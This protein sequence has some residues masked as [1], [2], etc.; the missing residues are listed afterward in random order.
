MPLPTHQLT[1]ARVTTLIFLLTMTS[2]ALGVDP[3]GA[4]N[5]L[6]LSLPVE[7]D[8]SSFHSPCI[9]KPFTVL[10]GVYWGVWE[11]TTELCAAMGTPANSDVLDIGTG[12]GILAI[13]ALERGAR[14]AIATDINPTAVENARL[15]AR[16]R[17]LESKL[18]ARLVPVDNPSAYSIIKEGERFDLIVCAC[19]A[20]DAEVHTYVDA[21]AF[22]PRHELV[23]S[24]LR[25]L[26]THLQPG[27]KLLMSYWTGG[28][29]LLINLVKEN[30]L[31][32]TVLKNTGL[33][34]PDSGPAAIDPLELYKIPRDKIKDPIRWHD[35]GVIVEIAPSASQ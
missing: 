25:G 16:L 12:S 18:D 24:L 22:D 1:R 27:G 2:F 33:K 10:R 15:N 5:T 9:E 6:A 3:R 21:N 19:P 32:L 30:A 8:H 34:R 13:T 35:H 31:K 11:D 4:V 20:F 28:M 7:D 26:K 17:N 14:S 23:I 29:D